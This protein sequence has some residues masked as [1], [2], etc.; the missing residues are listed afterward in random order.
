M[1]QEL[2]QEFHEKYGLPI[3]IPMRPSPE[4]AVI[5]SDAGSALSFIAT[6]LKRGESP[7]EKRFGKLLEE[8]AEMMTAVSNWDEVG[9]FDGLVDSSYVLNGIGVMYNFPLEDGFK[10]VHKSNMTKTVT[11]SL[12]ANSKGP[13]FKPPNLNLILETYRCKR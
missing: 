2:V 3:H 10:E 4:T 6:K 5:L 7:D 12:V 8:V 13:D 9:A 1:L 11:D